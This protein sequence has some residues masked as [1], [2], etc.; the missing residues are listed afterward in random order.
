MDKCTKNK[1]D[2]L[3]LFFHEGS[4]SEEQEIQAHVDSCKECRD[5]LLLLRQ[6]DQ[7]LRQ[8]QDEAPLPDTFDLILSEIPVKQSAPAPAPVRPALSLTPLLP[9][10]FSIMT[11]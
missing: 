7:T 1:D 3:T 11:E 8:W 5:Y 9:I 2:L 10:V 4:S 6:M